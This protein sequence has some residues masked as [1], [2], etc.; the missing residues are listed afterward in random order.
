MYCSGLAASTQ[1]F[2]R[3]RSYDK[4]NPLEA[5]GVWLI[6][7][8]CHGGG[9]PSVLHEVMVSLFTEHPRLAPELWLAAGEPQLPDYDSI[10]SAKLNLSQETTAAYDADEVVMLNAEGRHR[11]A[12]IVEVQLN[13]DEDKQ[14]SWPGYVTSARFKKR[15][16]AAVLVITPAAHVARWARRP[17][18]LGAGN[19]PRANPGRFRSTAGDSPPG[20]DAV[21][22]HRSWSKPA[23]CGHGRGGCCGGVHTRRR[24][25]RSLH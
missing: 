10:T 23:C 8:T 21:V 24:Q 3:P 20:A 17:I 16:D 25:T 9:M 19:R 15:C 13:L 22:A 12:L 18:H 1:T 4:G 7:Y 6:E 2:T 5:S 11:F 14:F